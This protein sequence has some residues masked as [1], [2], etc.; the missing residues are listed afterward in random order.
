[1]W[2]KWQG[3]VNVIVGGHVIRRMSDAPI[4]GIT[5]MRKP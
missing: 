5:L 4:P 2:L 3:H 1:M